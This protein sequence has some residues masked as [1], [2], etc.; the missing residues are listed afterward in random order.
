MK[1]SMIKK[2]IHLLHGIDIKDQ[3]MILEWPCLSS[4]PLKPCSQTPL[5]A[6]K[7]FP[8]YVSLSAHRIYSHSVV[9][10]TPPC[11]CWKWGHIA[12]LQINFLALTSWVHFFFCKQWRAHIFYFHDHAVANSPHALHLLHSPNTHKNSCLVGVGTTR[13]T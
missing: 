11:C 8:R 12:W 3:I 13:V 9:L 2:L 4:I 5:V 10:L 7:L 6:I 1:K